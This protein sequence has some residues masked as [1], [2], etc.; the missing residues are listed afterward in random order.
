M[1][2]TDSMNIGLSMDPMMSLPVII[3]ASGII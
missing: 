1:V 3:Y 2:D